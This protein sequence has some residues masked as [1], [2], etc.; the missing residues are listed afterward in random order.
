L[1]EGL[2][3][4]II[5]TSRV[6]LSLSISAAQHANPLRCSDP[7]FGVAVVFGDGVRFSIGLPTS[8]PEGPSPVIG[9]R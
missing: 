2:F 1:L 3:L 4:V 8:D 9:A 6:G 5:A 7:E